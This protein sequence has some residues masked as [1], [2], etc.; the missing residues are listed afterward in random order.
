MEKIGFFYRKIG[1]NRNIYSFIPII[2]T[3]IATLINYVLTFKY[4]RIKLEAL[5]NVF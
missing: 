1:K 3:C 2:K 4:H 5:K